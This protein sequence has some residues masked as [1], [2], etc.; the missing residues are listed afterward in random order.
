MACSRLSPLQQDLLPG[1][2]ER[3]RAFFLTGGAAP[4]GYCLCHRE[5]ARA[6][7]IGSHVRSDLGATAHATADITAT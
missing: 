3:E 5:N 1:F 4:A 6:G 7:A 2:F